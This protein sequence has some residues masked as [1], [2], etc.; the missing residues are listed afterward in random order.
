ML[1]K[2]RKILKQFEVWL[3]PENGHFSQVRRT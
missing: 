1:V 2:L 3:R